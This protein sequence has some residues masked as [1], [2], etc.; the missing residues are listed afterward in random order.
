MEDL[1][2]SLSIEVKVVIVNLGGCV[3]MFSLFYDK[4]KLIIVNLCRK[5]W[6]M[7]V[8]LIFCV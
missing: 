7:V 3:E 2:E 5:K 4:M 6:K 8:N 1:F